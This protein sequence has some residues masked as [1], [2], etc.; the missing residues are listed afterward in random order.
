M[1]P[2]II[3]SGDGH[4]GQ[5]FGGY[6]DYIDPAYR[7]R[8]SDLAEIQE[9]FAT[10][11]FGAMAKLPAEVRAVIDERGVRTGL[12]DVFWDVD[13]RV[14]ELDAEGIACEL[15]LADSSLAP[16]FSSLGDAYPAPLRSAGSRAFN[17]W[18]GEFLSAAGGRIVGNAEI[19]PDDIPGTV[20]DLPKLAEQG[21]VSITLPGA[22]A[23]NSLPSLESPEYEP[24]WAKCAE[25]GL[26][27]SVHAGWGRPQGAAMKFFRAL[28]DEGKS[29]NMMAPEEAASQ[30]SGEMMEA[31]ERLGKE[32]KIDAKNPDSPLA[33][34]LHPQQALWRL[35]LAGVFDRYP[36]LQLVLTEVRAD[37][38][39]ATLK[40]L[41]QRFTEH[42]GRCKLK[43]SEYY[44]RN[45]V[46]TPSAPH[47]AEIEMLDQIG[48]SKF[49]FGADIPHPESTWPNTRQW[50]ADAFRGL[51]ED[52]LR[53]VLGEN[54]IRVYH[55]DRAA[56]EKTAARLAITPNDLFSGGAL[57]DRLLANFDARA[58]YRR[59]ADEVDTER[60]GQEL[61]QDF[62]RLAKV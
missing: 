45:C 5:P 61:D 51:P 35:M 30:E 60:I 18:A 11:V 8:L 16:F 57:D 31:L 21:F 50:I 12:P 43:P 2:L 23:D 28:A 6:R 4:I 55:L 14:A 38:V 32:K 58:G 40:Y 49:M 48:V 59:P 19:Y 27:L 39:P 15:V 1:D 44:E 13:K 33:L 34:T 52:K 10:V 62:A 42:P 29:A 47:R 22:N 20:A 46:V 36:T 54:A 3:F 56:L 41:D 24:L 25:L 9:F 37:W 7:D 53:T 17:R 26:A